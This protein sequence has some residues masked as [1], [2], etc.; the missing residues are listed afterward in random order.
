MAMVV[1]YEDKSGPARWEQPSDLTWSYEQFAAVQ[2]T[3]RSREPPV[4]VPLLFESVFRGH[5]A[6]EAWTIKTAMACSGWEIT[7]ARASGCRIL[8]DGRSA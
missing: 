6:M 5:G 8:G 7:F 1:E 4:L 3:E 2:P